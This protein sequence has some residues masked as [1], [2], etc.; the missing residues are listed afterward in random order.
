MIN[1]KQIIILGNGQLGKACYLE[2]GNDAILFARDKIDF[3]DI[4]NLKLNLHILLDNI[5]ILCIINCVAY[6]NVDKA[7][8][9]DRELADVI[10]GKA[11]EVIGLYCKTRDVPLLHFSTDFIFDGRSPEP[12]NEQDEPNPINGYGASK[13]LGEKLLLDSYD[14]VL[15]FRIAWVY[16]VNFNTN[17]VSKVIIAMSKNSQISIPDDQIG[18]LCNVFDLSKLLH[19]IVDKIP[20]NEIINWGIYNIASLGFESRYSIVKRILKTSQI[21]DSKFIKATEILPISTQSLNSAVQRPLNSRLNS[22]KLFD[23][24]GLRMPDWIFSLHNATQKIIQKLE[25]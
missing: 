7:E 17:F 12:Y 16:S 11:V 8:N 14:K 4:S 10:N 5:D 23:S 2:F 22:Q 20:D 21:I 3:S 24:F 6:T 25:K 15:I 1:K 18:N 13:L 19:K 9:E